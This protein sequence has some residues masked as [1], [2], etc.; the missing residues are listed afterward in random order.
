M[1]KPA[2]LGGQPLLSE[3]LPKDNSIDHREKEAVLEVLD[4][5]VLS[6]FY[7]SPSPRF[8]GGPKVRELEQRWQEYFD[9]PY[10]V[11]VNSAT[12]GLHAAVL[13][14][15]VGPGDEVVVPP[16]T[17]SATASSVLMANAVPVFADIN[18][19]NFCLDLDSVRLVAGPLTKAIIAVNLFGGPA[20]LGPLM[21]FC[22]ERNIVLIEDNAQGPG[23]LY[24]NRF[25][26]VLCSLLVLADFW[27]KDLMET[28]GVATVDSAILFG[29]VPLPGR[30]AGAAVLAAVGGLM[31]GLM[32]LAA[33]R[34]HGG[35]VLYRAGCGLLLSGLAALLLD[36]LVRGGITM[37]LESGVG[38]A[39]LSIVM[40]IILIL[41]SVAL[42]RA[43][44]GKG[45]RIMRRKVAL[46]SYRNLER[47]MTLIEI[48]VVVTILA[49]MA[50]AVSLSV[51][52]LIGR[53]KIAKAKG[54]IASFTQALDIYYMENGEYPGGDGLQAL[55]SSG[56]DGKSLLKKKEI[57]KDPWK[58]EYIFRNPGTKNPDTYDVCSRGPDKQ[59]GTQDDICNE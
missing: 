14:A 57:P 3:T 20:D 33:V 36:L 4:S 23:G 11:S 9:V 37:Y 48:M 38:M 28:L 53:A 40:G 52:K 46:Y 39:D 44:R 47:G 2:I 6:D 50:T 15:G 42:V 30:W 10:A 26:L 27:S 21:D 5:G 34:W 17:M 18:D 35:T 55:L 54:D 16:Y 24:R 59:E 25:L 58:N 22:Q 12:S 56:D 32:I 13:A 19:R 49:L 8:L 7:G 31:G 43:A 45:K 1:G 41:S 51:V 29:L